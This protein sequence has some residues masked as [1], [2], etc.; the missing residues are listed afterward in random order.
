MRMHIVNKMRYSK[1]KID[2]AGSTIAKKLSISVEEHN[3]Y[4]KI[5]DWWREAHFIPLTEVTLKLIEWF[6]SIESNVHVNQRLK[7]KPQI[8]KKLIR[9]KNMRLSQ[10]RDIGGCRAIFENN[11]KIDEVAD[12]IRTKA[13]RYKY[14]SIV[15]E[16]DYRVNGRVESGYRALHITVERNGFQ[17]EIQLRSRIQHYWAEAIERTS[18]LCETSLKEGEGFPEIIDYFKIVSDAFFEIDYLRK[19]SDYLI[20]QIVEKEVNIRRIA[21]ANEKMTT[22]GKAINLSFMR[23]MVEREKKRKGKIKN[24]VLIFDWKKGIFLYWSE[25]G[26][27]VDEVTKTYSEKEKNFPYED[28]YEVVLIGSTSVESI[29]ETH[30]HYFGVESY[31]EI[32]SSIHKMV[33]NRQCEISVAA[34]KVLSKLYSHGHWGG[35]TCS[36]DTV[37][38][39]YCASENCDQALHELAE[40]GL[41]NYSGP[42]A[43]ISLISR[44]R[45]KIEEILKK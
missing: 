21:E 40:G 1:S 39:H 32:I 7:R 34:Y 24:W 17:I 18:V 19:P 13:R 9:K 8:L 25:T 4:E 41:V 45:V 43:P 29:K 42:K 35:N 16:A 30:S 33:D 14:F 27:T 28:G 38:N 36:L 31:D 23:A 22:G 10:M 20:Q 11:E 26:Y 44:K 6:Q 37:S 5:I 15:S 2:K 12:L 3:N